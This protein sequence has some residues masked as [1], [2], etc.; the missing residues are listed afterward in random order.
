MHSL[1]DKLK[2]QIKDKYTKEKRNKNISDI[3]KEW[4]EVKNNYYRDN[5]FSLYGA[6]NALTYQQTHSEG[7][8]LDENKNAMNRYQSLI[9]GPC[10]NRIDIAR[11]KCLQLTR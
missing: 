1:Q 8:I 7:R 4:N 6:F 3:D 9:S 11:E 2:G 5:D 10:G